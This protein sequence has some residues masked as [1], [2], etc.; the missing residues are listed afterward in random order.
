MISNSSS[1]SLNL[2]LEIIPC[3]S[4]FLCCFLNWFAMKWISFLTGQI[5]IY[6]RTLYFLFLSFQTDCQNY[7]R[8]LHKMPDGR[9]YVC[10]TS[11]FSPTCDYMVSNFLC[12]VTAKCHYYYV[13][14]D[15]SMVVVFVTVLLQHVDVLCSL[16][17]VSASRL[18]QTAT[19][20]W[21]INNMMER[22]SVHLILSRDT[23]L[24]LLVG[25]SS[26]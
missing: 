26:L 13:T 9:M 18:I 20:F 10:G 7:I 12:Y 24:S 22:E 4:S 19:W 15:V 17:Y 6:H 3:Y 25:A 2:V 1:V 8:I 23:P 21:K 14:V 16:C 5:V 11:A